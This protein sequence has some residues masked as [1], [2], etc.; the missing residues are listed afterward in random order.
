MYG[1]D[2]S[3]KKFRN[4]LW[5][6]KINQSINQ[7]I[8]TR[9]NFLHNVPMQYFLEVIKHTAAKRRLSYICNESVLILYLSNLIIIVAGMWFLEK[10]N[11]WA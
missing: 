7:S 9:A 5:I 10:C 8:Y 1:I 4:L 3:S 6:C 11:Q 2:F